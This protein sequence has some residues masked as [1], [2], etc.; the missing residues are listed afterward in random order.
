MTIMS[1]KNKYAHEECYVIREDRDDHPDP[2]SDL[3][4]DSGELIPLNQ[5][6]HCLRW[7]CDSH[8]QGVCVECIDDPFCDPSKK[9]FMFSR[10]DDK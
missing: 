4:Y 2:C 6:S 5:C 3:Y 1:T 9:P 7:A 10:E 8:F